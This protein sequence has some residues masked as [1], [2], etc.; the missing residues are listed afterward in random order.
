LHPSCLAHVVARSHP[1]SCRGGI[2][3]RG[4]RV[5]G[6][7]NGRNGSRGPAH[8]GR[9][10]RSA[11]ICHVGARPRHSGPSAPILRRDGRHAYPRSRRGRPVR[12]TGKVG[13]SSGRPSR[14]GGV[15]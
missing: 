3:A 2:V 11:R 8:G 7:P 15:R 12:T 1:G 10:A 9:I 5:S 4:R 14:R 6:A 13:T